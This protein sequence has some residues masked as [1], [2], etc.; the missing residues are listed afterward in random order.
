MG[1]HDRDSY[2]QS[3]PVPSSTGVG[4]VNIATVTTWL[5]VINVAVFVL[6][7][8][9][10]RMDVTYEDVPIP[11]VHIQPSP[12][13]AGIG[14]FSLG[15][16]FVK[17]EIWRVL[18]FQFIHA[19]WTHLLLNMIGLFFFGPLIESYLGRRKYLAFYLLSGVGGAVG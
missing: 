19:S 2:R 11:Q 15:M 13:I 4:Q 16:F 5:I 9:L 10:W 18:T 14:Y 6:D 3:P 7:R 1:I 17:G 12:P 8:V